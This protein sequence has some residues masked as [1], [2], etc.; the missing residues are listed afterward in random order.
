MGYTTGSCAALAAKAAAEMLLSRRA[1]TEVEILTPGGMAVKT[2][3]LEAALSADRASCAIRKDAGDDPDITDG[4]LVFAQV[5]YADDGQITVEGGEGV[6]RVTRRGLDQPVG[7]AAINSTPRRMIMQEVAECCEAHGYDGGLHVIIS[8]PGGEALAAKTFN[9]Q[10]GIVGGLSVIGTSGIVEPMSTK[11]ILDTIDTEMAMLEAEGVRS[12]LLTP[13]N[14]GR[15]F[16]SGHGIL[17]NL[18]AVKCSNFIGDALDMAVRHGFEEVL[19]LGHIGKLVKLAGGIMDT[20]SS[21]ADA[22]MELLALHGALAGGDVAFLRR[23]LACATTEE[24]VNL[25]EEASCLV[26][27]MESL[28]GAMEAAVRRRVRDSA[29]IGVLTFSSGYGELGHSAGA[30]RLMEQWR[31]NHE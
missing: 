6:G 7:A 22:R 16:L 28:L 15:N 8:I 2:L 21:V 26:P 3:V 5:R 20:H 11:A 19:V 13:G 27:V 29:A 18:P 4:V 31:G 9:P 10:L 14:Y 24:A 25:M 1:V 23:I 12:I 30:A 17:G